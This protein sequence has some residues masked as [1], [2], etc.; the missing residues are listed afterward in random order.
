MCDLWQQAKVEE[1]TFFEEEE[2]Q[3]V[4]FGDF[5]MLANKSAFYE[6][7]ATGGRRFRLTV[8]SG[9]HKRCTARALSLLECFLTA[10]AELDTLLVFA[11]C[12]TV[13]KTIE[14]P[15]QF[16][17]LKKSLKRVGFSISAI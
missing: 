10:R 5:E 16:E 2:E 15:D 4:G 7:T 14:L 9:V 12:V 8:L 13:S 11:G 6:T 3:S 1:R 17:L